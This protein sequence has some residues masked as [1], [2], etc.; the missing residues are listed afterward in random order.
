[1][2]IGV[3][4][5][6]ASLLPFYSYSI[7]AFSGSVTAWHGFFG[8]FGVLLGMAAAGVLA[9][10]LFGDLA[11]ASVRT[12]VLGLFAGS[13]FFLFLA[14]FV[15]PGGDYPAIGLTS[16]HSFGYWLALLLSLAATVLAYRRKE[17]GAASS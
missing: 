9:A 16:G 4:L 1:M 3:L 15:V 12:I 11:I 14:L 17:A 5:F 10:V 7:A 8:W 6:I 2:G 13:A